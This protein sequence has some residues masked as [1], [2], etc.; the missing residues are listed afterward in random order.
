MGGDLLRLLQCLLLLCWLQTSSALAE[1]IISGPVEAEL[2]QVIDGDSIVVK[3]RIWFGQYVEIVVK[4]AGIDAPA[5]EGNC[6]A[7]TAKGVEARDFLEQTLQDKKL[8]L[9]GIESQ[10]YAGNVTAI[11]KYDNNSDISALLLKKELAVPY[12]GKGSKRGWCE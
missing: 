6:A 3:A 8:W 12:Y 2:L 5:L 1:T 7:E 9:Y 4:I 11:V 10:R